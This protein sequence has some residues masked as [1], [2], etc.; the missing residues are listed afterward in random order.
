M[1]TCSSVREVSLARL[2]AP[3]GAAI[4]VLA[5]QRRRVHAPQATT[6]ALPGRPALRQLRPHRHSFG[7]VKGPRLPPM[8]PLRGSAYTRS[9]RAA[10]CC[11]FWRTG[12]ASTVQHWHEKAKN[13]AR[14]RKRVHVTAPDM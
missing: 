14:K 11:I 5:L 2:R 12:F 1:G 13:L 3:P 10:L 4:H 8:C 7:R 9:S 6:H